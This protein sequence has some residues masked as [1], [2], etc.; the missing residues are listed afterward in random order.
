M[1]AITRDGVRTRGF[2]RA[3]TA[4]GAAVLVGMA[5]T[6]SVWEA[7]QAA[8]AEAAVRPLGPKAFEGPGVPQF[9]FDPTWP[10]LPL[11]NNWIFGNM[12]G[13]HVDEKDHVWILQR[14]NTVQ[15]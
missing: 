10:K 13:V 2:R 9:E 4:L 7:P 1:S 14:G 3:S 8:T 5:L 12:S 15:L 6:L 11:P